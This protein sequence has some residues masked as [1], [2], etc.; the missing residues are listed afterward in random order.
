[1]IQLSKVN[2][3]KASFLKDQ[4]T[5]IRKNSLN[6]TLSNLSH[7]RKPRRSQQRLSCRKQSPNN[8]HRKPC[9]K[10]QKWHNRCSTTLTKLIFQITRTR[11]CHNLYSPRSKVRLIFRLKTPQCWNRRVHP[12]P[13]RGC[14][15]I[16]LR[17]YN[18]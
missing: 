16:L 3:S 4:P 1:M 10:I 17:R 12:Q 18:N 15:A 6:R 5:Q 14:I 9:S 13:S 11:E 8:Q 2:L 7:K